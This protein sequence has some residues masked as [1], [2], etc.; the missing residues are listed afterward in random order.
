MFYLQLIFLS[1]TINLVT[2]LNLAHVEPDV[3]NLIDMQ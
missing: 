1:I 3:P 2:V